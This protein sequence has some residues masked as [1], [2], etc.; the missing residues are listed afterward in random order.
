M[1]IPHKSEIWTHVVV[2]PC[3]FTT[4]WRKQLHKAADLVLTLPEGHP[5]SW[6]A[7]MHE[8]LMIAILFPFI[9]HRPWQLRRTPKLMELGNVV[10]KVWKSGAESDGPL[11]RNFGISRGPWQVCWRA[12]HPMCYTA[13]PLV[14]FRIAGPENDEGAEWRKEK[15]EERFLC[16]QNGDMLSAPFQCD[17]CWFVNLQQR[18]ANLVSWLISCLWLISDGLTWIS[19]GPGKR[20]LLPVL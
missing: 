12:W 8:P 10:Q 14:E 16:A 3:L 17:H 9:S 5:P 13:S 19:C 11:L 6:P 1:Q 2:I 15:E 18:E 4:E 20:L 7:E